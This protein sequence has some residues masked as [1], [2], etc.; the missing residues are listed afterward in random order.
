MQ[1]QR[2]FCFSV[3][4]VSQGFRATV[5]LLSNSTLVLNFLYDFVTWTIFQL[6]VS[7]SVSQVLKLS[8]R[9]VFVFVCPAQIQQ[10]HDMEEVCYNKVLE[11]VKAGHQVSQAVLITAKFIQP[12]FYQFDP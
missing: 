3:K 10:I 4:L 5:N 7:E 2:L 1:K 12:L 8:L 11:Q 9:F 6:K